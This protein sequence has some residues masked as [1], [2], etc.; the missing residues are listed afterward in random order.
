MSSDLHP[1]IYDAPEYTPEPDHEMIA[2]AARIIRDCHTMRFELPM[3]SPLR[4]LIRDIE[5]NAQIMAK[6]AGSGL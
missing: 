3:H 2:H 1:P 6:R 5:L 4:A